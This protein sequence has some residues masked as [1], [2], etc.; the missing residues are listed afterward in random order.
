MRSIN[1]LLAY[2]LLTY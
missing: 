1:F 2:Y